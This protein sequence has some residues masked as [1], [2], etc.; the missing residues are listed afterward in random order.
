M[1]STNRGSLGL[2]RSQFTAP[3]QASSVSSAMTVP[4]ITE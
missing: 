1:S 4:P 3:N 2:R